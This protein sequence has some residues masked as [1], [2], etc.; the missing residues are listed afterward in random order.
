MNL[1]AKVFAII[2]AVAL[3]VGL[4]HSSYGGN[5]G[6]SNDSDT[7]LQNNVGEE[8]STPKVYTSNPFQFPYNLFH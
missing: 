2:G 3:S 8:A 4:I 7:I 6:L 1:T 5:G